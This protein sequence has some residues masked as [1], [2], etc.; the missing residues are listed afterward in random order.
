MKE[1]H[2]IETLHSKKEQ[3]LLATEVVR[4]ISLLLYP[5]DGKQH[6]WELRTLLLDKNFPFHGHDG[7]HTKFS[8]ETYSLSLSTCVQFIF[9]KTSYDIVNNK[10]CPIC[11]AYI[12]L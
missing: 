9:I 10:R 1:Q 4:N 2:V 5:D 3:I 8:S 7:P 6:R 11:I 12:Y